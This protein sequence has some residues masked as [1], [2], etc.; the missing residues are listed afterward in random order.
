MGDLVM[1]NWFDDSLQVAAPLMRTLAEAKRINV[2]L[3]APDR[4]EMVYL[5][6]IRY[7][8]R[9]AFRNAVSGQRVPVELTSQ[10]PDSSAGSEENTAI[11]FPFPAE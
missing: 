7:S 11:L 2:G 6:S 8:R 1:G 3:A 5:E 9:A 10:Y 4:D